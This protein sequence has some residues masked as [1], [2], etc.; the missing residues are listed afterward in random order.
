MSSALNMGICCMLPI[1][2]L[3]VQYWFWKYCFLKKIFLQLFSLRW[4]S[5]GWDDKTHLAS[6]F[7]RVDLD[8][9][10]SI[11]S[12]EFVKKIC[13]PFYRRANIYNRYTG[14]LKNCYIGSFRRYIPPKKWVSGSLKVRSSKVGPHAAKWFTTLTTLGISFNTGSGILYRPI[15]VKN[16]SNS[17]TASIAYPSTYP[18]SISQIPYESTFKTQ[19]MFHIN[20]M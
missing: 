14:L 9:K 17:A 11:S 20:S 16:V 12:F 6:S 18:M 10:A 13:W 19:F 7:I 4:L 15:L 5:F 1:S 2:Y 8:W 3:E